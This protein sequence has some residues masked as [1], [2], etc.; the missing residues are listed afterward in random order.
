MKRSLPPSNEWMP[1]L[2]EQQFSRYFHIG[3][4]RLKKK[5]I[6]FEWDPTNVWR[7]LNKFGHSCNCSYKKTGHCFAMTSY[8][9]VWE[10]RRNFYNKLN[11]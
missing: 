9:Y 8:K 4:F 2:C 10:M 3:H 1:G 11:L 7:R 6:L 5:K